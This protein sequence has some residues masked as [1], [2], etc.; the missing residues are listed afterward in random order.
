MK[1]FDHAWM[2]LQPRPKDL[3]VYSYWEGVERILKRTTRF[4]PRERS[5]I[6]VSRQ[7]TALLSGLFEEIPS[8][9]IIV[10]PTN[11][12]DAVPLLM[13]LLEIEKKD[14]QANVL[15]LPCHEAEE[16]KFFD[17]VF[18]AYA[19]LQN[20]CQNALLLGMIPSSLQEE[21]PE[22][23]WI[24]PKFPREENGYSVISLIRQADEHFARDLQKQ[25]GLYD[26]KTLL[27][28]VSVFLLF[29]MLANPS[30]MRSFLAKAREGEVV[31]SSPEDVTE[32]EF[33]RDI[34]Q[35][36]L[37]FVRAVPIPDC[38]LSLFSSIPQKEM[39]AL[40]IWNFLFRRFPEEEMLARP[41]R[42]LH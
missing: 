18:G 42:L 24:V 6:M 27:A 39:E 2:V 19:L 40:Q 5:M 38:G 41:R 20:G 25:G 23:D 10:Y 35:A 16:E 30:M 11:M 21:L 7:D 36:N 12:G 3:D 28:P 32:L 4:I 14:R 13:L 29:Y 15:L 37:P 34:L 31:F 26:T 1:P 9:N 8:P 33:Y 17:G 22:G